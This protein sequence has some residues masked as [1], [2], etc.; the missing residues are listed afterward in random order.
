MKVT[1]SKLREN[2]YQIL[3][4]VI[5]DGEPVEIVRK[6]SVLRIVPEVLESKLSRLK[7]RRGF[8]GNPD[9][10]AGMDWSSEWNEL[11]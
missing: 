10:I 9:E 11:K 8:K 5:L 7:K 3:D 1:A 2:I 4:Q 6:G